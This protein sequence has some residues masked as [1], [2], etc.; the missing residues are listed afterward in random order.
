M[1]C[2][3]QTI[4]LRLMRSLLGAIAPIL[5]DDRGV[6]AAIVAI[7]LPALIGFGALGV[8]TGAWFTTKLRNQSAADAAAISA[9]Y[10]ILAGKTHV[11]DDLIPAAS[12]AATR[13]G[14]NGTTPAV[15]YPYSDAI[16]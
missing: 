8:E 12:E 16:T 6:S 7:A 15:E 4:P 3:P 13:N 2:R 5:R 11:V 9:G 10:Q 1:G 14:Y